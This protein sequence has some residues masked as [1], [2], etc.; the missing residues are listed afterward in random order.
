MSAYLGN[1]YILRRYTCL[2]DL[3]LVGFPQVKVALAIGGFIRD[4]A[5]CIPKRILN[6]R[7]DFGTNFIMAGTDGGTNPRKKYQWA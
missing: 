1:L 5:I 7:D 6:L 3:P 4:I 2:D